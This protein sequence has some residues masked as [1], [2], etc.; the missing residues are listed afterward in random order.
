MAVPSG[1]SEKESEALAIK[2]EIDQIDDELEP[3]IEKYNKANVD[4]GKIREAMAINTQR[5]KEAE[6]KLASGRKILNQ[7]LAGIYRNGGVS[8]VQVIFGSKSFD[9]F[10]RR[11]DMLK[12]IGKKDALLVEEIIT[13]K[14]EIERTKAVL[15][16]QERVAAGKLV[17]IDQ[18]KAEIE[19]RLA[20]RNDKLALIQDEIE[21]IKRVEE[22]E[23]ARTAEELRRRLEAERAA[24][25]DRARISPSSSRGEGRSDVVEIALQYLGV[26]YVWGGASPSGFDCSGFTMYVFAQVGID[27]PHDAEY[28]YGYG[29]HVT[30]DELAPGD[31]VFFSSGG[32][33]IGH[34]GIYVGD[35]QYIHAPRTG[36]VVR[37]DY[38]AD[39]MGTYVGATRL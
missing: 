14:R 24:A 11:F 20:Q 16:V 15:Q 38:V 28:Q 29:T 2:A 3:V 12:R 1:L 19:S 13:A 32:Y 25:A 23:A 10:V 36:D 21:E 6:T 35:G 39:R 5:L 27:L 37:I 22:E 7:R 30:Y 33:W 9:E 8:A 4:L 18:R 26:P 34:V 17:D 31:L